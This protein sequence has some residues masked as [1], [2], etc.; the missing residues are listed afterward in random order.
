M[1]G[2]QRLGLAVAAVRQMLGRPEPV[3][4]GPTAMFPGLARLT[5]SG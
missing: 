3:C 2:R 5:S 1:A 4:R